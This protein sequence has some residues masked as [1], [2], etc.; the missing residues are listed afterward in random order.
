MRKG[1][2]L[3]TL[4]AM[5]LTSCGVKEESSVNSVYHCSN[6]KNSSYA[7]SIGLNQSVYISF[8]EIFEELDKD[9]SLKTLEEWVCKNISLTG[10]DNEKKSIVSLDF[11]VMHFSSTSNLENGLRTIEIKCLSEFDTL[12]IKAIRFTNNEQTLDLD[13]DISLEFNDDYARYP[14]FL[15][16]YVVDSR[17]WYN[18]GVFYYDH[19]RFSER[20][21]EGFFHGYLYMFDG[22]RYDRNSDTIVLNDITFSE[23]VNPYVTSVKYGFFDPNIKPLDLIYEQIDFTELN[24]PISLNDV[25]NDNSELLFS[26]EYEELTD[27]AFLGGDII[28]DITINGIN[29]N[30]KNMYLLFNFYNI[31]P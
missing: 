6:D 17:F 31:Y 8:A 20:N 15:E 16:S 22:K 9:S 2:P 29:Y 19:L 30:I 18:G 7:Y 27:N 10:F 4:I 11:K 13:T 5:V 23:N 14:S 21:L 3:F 12:E 1:I 25:T 26:F 24:G 28:Y